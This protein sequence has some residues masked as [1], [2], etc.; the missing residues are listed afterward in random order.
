MSLKLLFDA[1]DEQSKSFI[2]FVLY[3]EE[4]SLEYYELLNCI[5]KTKK[6]VTQQ[7]KKLQLLSLAQ[8]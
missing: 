7:K 3:N 2:G 6:L 1:T 8:R 4:V 5:L